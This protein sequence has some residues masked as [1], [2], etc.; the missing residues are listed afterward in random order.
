ML[1]NTMMKL[2][3]FLG[4]LLYFFCGLVLLNT[5]QIPYSPNALA[6][7]WRMIIVCLGDIIIL[8]LFYQH[9]IARYMFKAAPTFQ[10]NSKISIMTF[11]LALLLIIIFK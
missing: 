10:L 2:L 8:Y 9:I 6:H 4:L 5:I 7:F 3:G 1:V 11:I